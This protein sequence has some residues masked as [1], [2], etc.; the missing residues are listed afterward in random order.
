MDK[1]VL[2]LDGFMIPTSKSFLDSLSPGV[3][4]GRGVFETMRSYG[5]KIF[6]L[7]EHLS[8]LRRGLRLLSVKM[9]VSAEKIRKHLYLTLNAN[10]LRDARLRLTVW[11]QKGNPRISI[12][13]LPYRPY[14]REKYEEG[15]KAVIADVR[16]N[17][18]SKFS[19][20]KS[21]HYLPLAIALR[22]AEAKGNDETI[23]LNRRGFL[24]EGSRSNIFY[25]KDGV[26]LTPDL[27]CGCLDGVT[28]KIVL[29]IARNLKIKYKEV[30][31]LPENLTCADE[32]FLTNSLLEIMPLTFLQGVMIGKGRIGEITSKLLSS[33]RS[34]VREKIYP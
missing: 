31:A 17:E 6:L 8:R 14:P 11:E 4:P 29:K 16:R 34:F 33:Y 19:R 7:E 5:G 28:R 27:S 30:C 23:F 26:L 21:I 22:R 1:K 25:V 9:P 2:F 18:K 24:C 20:I 13:A 32:A 12:A 10:G 3:L 15:F